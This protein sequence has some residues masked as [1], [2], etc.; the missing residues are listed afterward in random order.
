MDLGALARR[1]TAAAKTV[2]W[3]RLRWTS[4]GPACTL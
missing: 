3:C 1:P 4:G 2:R